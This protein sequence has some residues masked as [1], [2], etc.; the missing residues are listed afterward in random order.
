MINAA[1]RWFKHVVDQAIRDGIVL[2]NHPQLPDKK[3]QERLFVV[4]VIIYV[5]AIIGFT[6]KVVGM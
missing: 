5:F 3:R 6:I 2:Y 4:T 1:R